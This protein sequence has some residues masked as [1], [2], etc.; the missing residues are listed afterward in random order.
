MLRVQKVR[1][2]PNE[3]MK[4]V[5]DDLCDYRRYCW[6]QGLALWN[7][8]Y[9][10]SLVLGDKKLRP[11][12]RKVRNELVANKEDWQYQLSARCLQ[13]AISD[14]GKAWSNFFKKSLPD[15]GKPKF[16]SKKTAR[17]GFNSP[18]KSLAPLKLISAQLLTPCG[19]SNRNLPLTI[20]ARSVLKPWRAVFLDLNFG[21][22]QFGND[23]LKKLLQALPKSEMASCKHRADSWY[24]QSSLLATNSS[25]C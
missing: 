22:P 9:D 8:M 1:L 2:D 15:W 23:F 6:N 4:Q 13:L 10:T 7:D 12:E 24:C 25:R 19:L 21:L 18:F 5:L 11:S 17:Q 16:K 20:W 14:L 3:T